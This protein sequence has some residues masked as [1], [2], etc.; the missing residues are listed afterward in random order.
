M[1]AKLE[2][3]KM[4][5]KNRSVAVIGIGIS[6]R[7]LIRYLC[8]LGARVTAC[9]RRSRDQLGEICAELEALGVLLRLGEGYLENLTQ[10]VI[11]KTPGMRFDVPALCRAK[12]GRGMGNLGNGGIF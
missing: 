5:I 1:N 10:E 7:P 4:N 2:Q 11:F 12:R 3:F 6:N 9:D 8:G